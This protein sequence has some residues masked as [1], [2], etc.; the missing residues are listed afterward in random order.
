MGSRNEARAGTT[1]APSRPKH[2]ALTWQEALLGSTAG[3]PAQTVPISTE[4]RCRE[5]RWTWDRQKFQFLAIVE[6]T[7]IQRGKSINGEMGDSCTGIAFASWTG[8][9]PSELL[10]KLVVIKT[11]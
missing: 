3:D 11:S 1:S 8:E 5:R 7:V 6:N 4:R 10:S 2:S 9:K